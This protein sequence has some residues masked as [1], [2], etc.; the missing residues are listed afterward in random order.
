[1][2]ASGSPGCSAQVSA[3][4]MLPAVRLH[5]S[6]VRAQY[7]ASQPL[8]RLRGVQNLSYAH[9]DSQLIRSRLQLMG[10][11]LAVQL[12][13]HPGVTGAIAASAKTAEPSTVDVDQAHRQLQEQFEGETNRPAQTAVGV[14]GIGRDLDWRR[15]WYPITFTANLPEGVPTKITLFD[16]D[17]VVVRRGGGQSPLA[18]VDRCP[19]RA[20]ALSQGVLTPQG[21][22]QC[23]YHGWAFD[24]AGSCKNIPQLPPDATLPK[25]TC[26][27]AFPAVEHDGFLWLQPSPL[28]P[29][30]PFDSST[31]NPVKELHGVLSEGEMQGLEWS[32][33]QFMRDFPIDYSLLLENLLD[34]D[35]GMYAHQTVAFDNHA[36]SVEHPMVV[37]EGRRH[38]RLTITSDTP[39]VAKL[40]PKR[41]SGLELTEAAEKAQKATVVFEAPCQV[42]SIRRNSD[43]TVASYQNFYAIPTGVGRCRFM[44]RGASPK[45]PKKLVSRLFGLFPSWLVAKFINRFLD[46]DSFLLASQQPLVLKAEAQAM[47][48][49]Q[50][51]DS[52][53]GNARAQVVRRAAYNYQTPSDALQVVVGRW[54]DAA[55]PNMPNRVHNLLAAYRSGGKATQ[56]PVR[57][58]VLDRWTQH[59]LVT[60]ASMA[61]YARFMRVRNILGGIAV[62]SAAVAAGRLSV[63]IAAVAAVA[64][65]VAMLCH[66]TA[67]TFRYAH[68]EEASRKDLARI[69]GLTKHLSPASK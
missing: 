61:A 38:G 41:L 24:E 7:A 11:G 25:S 66:S 50:S 18:L 20:A 34:P 47:E 33:T 15:E 19:H 27:A 68:S 42:N 37:R 16:E 3:A 13:A 64:T 12:A 30:Q 44:L 65:V 55:L 21:L 67:G 48:K 45:G 49:N 58:E 6:G 8:H 60:P 57:E 69:A 59:T 28:P 35:H 32:N 26:A 56:P 52:S 40:G 36:G 46:Q 62:F 17:Y 43:G 53:G 23:A 5:T 63:P 31:F 51:S 22:L 29:G 9:I 14:E 4:H 2:W 39:A 10:F 1:M 54:L